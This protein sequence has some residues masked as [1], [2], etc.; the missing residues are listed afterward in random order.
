MEM[1][2]VTSVQVVHIWD[3]TSFIRY[4]PSY[5]WTLN[6]SVV[7]VHLFSEDEEMV[8]LQNSGMGT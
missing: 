2:C 3:W 7:Y 8:L 1:Q 5:F 4:R 6:Q